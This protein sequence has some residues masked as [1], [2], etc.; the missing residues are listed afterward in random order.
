MANGIDGHTP[1]S[2]D[3]SLKIFGSIVAMIIFVLTM[4]FTQDSQNEKIEALTK[5]V[6]GLKAE[7]SHMHDEVNT[8]K[9]LMADPDRF[10]KK[11]EKA[12]L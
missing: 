2:L 3:T 4:K 12:K 5:E 7:V 11:Q 6:V 1:V 10:F 8:W 9:T